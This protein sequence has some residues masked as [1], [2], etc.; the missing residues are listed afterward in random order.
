MSASPALTQQQAE[1]LLAEVAA[2]HPARVIKT[3][4]Y[5]IRDE[6]SCL[7]GHVLHRAGWSIADLAT[8]DEADSGA[9]CAADALVHLGRFA[10][11]TPDAARLLR[12]AQE[13]QD[14]CAS[15][16][17]ATAAALVSTQAVAS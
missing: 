2:E 9:P 4:R 7:V 1:T 13:W 8:A 16:A 5:A 17:E 12:V 6:P 10:G 11:L 15:W 3:G 14:D